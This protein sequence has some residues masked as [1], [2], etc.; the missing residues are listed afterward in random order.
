MKIRVL[1][2]DDHHLVIDAL[3]RM[4]AAEPDIEIAGLA[5]NGVDVPLLAKQTRADVVCMDISMPGM[6]G[7]ETTAQMLA[8]YPSVRV[9]GLS[10]SADPRFILD[11]LKAGA[12]GYVT[13]A[14][15]GEDLLRAIRAVFRRQTYLCPIAA[16]AVAGVMCA[17]TA[18]GRLRT[19]RLGS[20]E[21][22]VLQLVAEGHT[23]SEIAGLLHI[24]PST[25]EVHRRNLMRKL[26]I[27]GVAELTTYAIKC[28]LVG[29]LGIGD[30]SSPYL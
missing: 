29:D 30:N 11:M 8:S 18:P 25:V 19:D 17:K 5:G 12:L 23:S 9:I 4:L 24:A 28:G 13:K 21:R 16:S 2:A 10:A 6:N 22:Q 15:A 3:Q 20:R 26:D 7:I 1:L 14:S 27:H